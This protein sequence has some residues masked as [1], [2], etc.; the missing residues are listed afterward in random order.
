MV[1]GGHV[2]RGRVWGVAAGGVNADYLVRGP[3]LPTPGT[4][5]EGKTSYVG[6]GGNGAT[7]AVAAARLGARVALPARLGSDAHGEALLGPLTRGGAW[8]AEGAGGQHRYDR[9]RRCIRR[10]AGS[11]LG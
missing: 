9:R 11:G 1:D 4:G 7:K 8:A 5:V 6:P 3:R 2:G 10:G